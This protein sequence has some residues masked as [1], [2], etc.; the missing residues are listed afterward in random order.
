MKKGKQLFV[1]VGTTQF[2]TLIEAVSEKSFE[3]QLEDDGYNKVVIQHGRGKAP[4]RDFDMQMESFAFSASLHDHMSSADVILCHA[5]AGSIMEALSL[6]KHVIVVVNNDLMDN[7]QLELAHALERRRLIGVV[8]HPKLLSKR[9]K[10]LSTG[11]KTFMPVIS[12]V[13]QENEF[14]KILHDHMGLPPEP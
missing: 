4:S 13:D 7:H 1:T 2:D 14:I 3:Q 8:S 9:W 5:G 10:E 11:S 6:Q 12:K